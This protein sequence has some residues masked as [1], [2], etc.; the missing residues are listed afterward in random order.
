MH[1]QTCTC[2][3]VL[4]VSDI[5]CVYVQCQSKVWR[6][7]FIPEM[8]LFCF[9]FYDRAQQINSEEMDVIIATTTKY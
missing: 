6:H 9:V 3:E 2:D 4:V 1:A 8:L 5:T 7:L